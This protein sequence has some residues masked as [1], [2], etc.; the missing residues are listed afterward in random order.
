MIGASAPPSDAR[1]LV[2]ERRA[3]VAHLRPE[4]LGDE[5]GLRPVHRG[6]ADQPADGGE[7]DQRRR[8]GV[9]QREEG[10]HPD[11]R[12]DRAREVHGPAA[13]PVRQVAEVGDQEQLQRR[14]DEHAAERQVLRQA[15]LRRDVGEDEQRERVEGH[16][17][18][19]A[20]RDRDPEL[21]RV[22][23][24]DLDQRR[25][26]LLARLLELLEERRLLDAQADEETDADQRRAEQERHPPAP[27]VEGRLRQHR[28]Q[29]RQHAGGEQV[30]RRARRPAASSSTARAGARRRA[31][32]PSAP[33][34]PTRRRG[35][36]PGRSAASRAGSGRRRRSSHRSAGSRSGTSRRPSA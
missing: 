9:Q 31:R 34:R 1:H 23:L 29:Q 13:D 7:H 30:A 6:V 22:A 2:A 15:E 3:G 11:R 24:D 12:G 18:A 36:G 19:E 32:R 25:L 21:A 14:A 5:R 33:R 28:G 26:L 4:Q 16:V 8:L 35:R 17:D 20:R 27:R 10:E